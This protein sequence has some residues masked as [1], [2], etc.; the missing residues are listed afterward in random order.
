[1]LKLEGVFT[2]L[3]TPFKGGDIDW[4]GLKKLVRQQ[5]DGG[6]NGLVVG[7]TTAESPTLSLEEKQKIFDFVKAESG[8]AVPLVMGTGSNSTAETISAT[9]KAKTWG[10]DA[11]LVV[12]PYYNKPSQRGLFLHFQAVARESSLPIIL[13]NVP[14]R[15]I[16][17]LEL[18]TI[19]E[20]SRV[21]GIVAIKEASGDLE[22]GAQIAKTTPLLLSS[23]DDG[24]FLPLVG[25]GG[26]GVISVISNLIPKEMV[27]L[28]ERARTGDVKG[29]AAAFEERFGPLNSSL[30][31]E[32]NPIPVKYAL[33][34][35][36]RIASAEMRL[37]LTELDQR[38]RSLLD[39]NI[40]KAGLL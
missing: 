25:N 39:G 30:Y 1:M 31:I 35:L 12:V 21:P 37:P 29:A 15:T 4:T 36:G 27:Q 32:A 2:A 8:Q 34:R 23:G 20:L 18:A 13:Y 7:G 24:T 17:K 22:F 16:T 14:S 38:H 9:K 28:F 33:Y 26:R 40:T 5:L 6:I 19:Q 10:A 11:A 3:V